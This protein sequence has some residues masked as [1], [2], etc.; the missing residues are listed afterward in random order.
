MVDE[1]EGLL[2]EVKEELRRERLLNL[3]QKYGTVIV[4]AALAF[5]AAISG[6]AYWQNMQIASAQKAGMS[7]QSATADLTRGKTDEAIKMFEAISADK[8]S[9][10]QTLADLQIAG[11]LIKKG[12]RAKAKEAYEAV[13]NDTG[14][15]QLLRDFATLQAVSLNIG[16]S[17]LSDVQNRLNRFNK[18]ESPWRTNARELIALSAFHS[19]KFDVAKENLRLIVADAA[20]APG[21]LGRANT[22]LNMIAAREVQAKGAASTGSGGGDQTGSAPAAPASASDAKAPDSAVAP[23]ATAKTNSG[24][25][26]K[27]SSQNKD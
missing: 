26:T 1:N 10:Y 25:T 15:D 18:P 13:A 21:V 16:E 2:R 17:D 6:W 12:D 3:W 14:A 8:S 20:A 5:V 4:T 9:N 19:E 11:S 23:E 22:L 27:P 24:D 7:Y